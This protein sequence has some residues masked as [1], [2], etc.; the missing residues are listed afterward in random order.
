MVIL[1]FNIGLMGFTNSSVLKIVNNPSA[2]TT[3][4]NLDDDWKA[5]NKTQGVFNQGVS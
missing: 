1:S 5:W 4:A 2:I 3:Y